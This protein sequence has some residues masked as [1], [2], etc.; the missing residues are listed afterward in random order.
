MY[1]CREMSTLAVFKGYILEDPTSE[2]N[3]KLD[4]CLVAVIFYGII[5]ME[6]GQLGYLIGHFESNADSSWMFDR[7]IREQC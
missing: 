1:Y 7:A 3:Q 5:A 6:V 2:T 4:D